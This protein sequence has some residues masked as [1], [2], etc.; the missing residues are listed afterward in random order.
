[1]DQRCIFCVAKSLE[2]LL[3]K[4]HLNENDRNEL[5]QKIFTDLGS[6]SM[7][8]LTPVLAS[9]IH[10]EIRKRLNNQDPYQE[11]KE[12]YNKLMLDLYAELKLKIKT[13]DNSFRTAVKTA[14]A[15][16]I[17]DF[18]ASHNFEVLETLDKVLHSDFAIDDTIE[19]KREIEKAETILYLG[20][21][22][23]EIVAD[24]LLLEE[25]AHKN[26][27]FAVRGNP[28]IND[29][30]EEDAHFVGIDKFAK[31][32]SNGY[33]AP[34]TILEHCSTEF[35][36]IWKKAD[37]VISKGQGNYEGLLNN[38]SKKI[39]FLLMVK[40]DYIAE[41]LNVRKGD[42]VAAKNSVINE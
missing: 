26:V 6:V 13:S 41:K 35:M 32:I 27:Y 3:E 36:E 8:T 38:V 11:E 22:A 4:H 29:I 18:G 25:M 39:F 34:S 20:D 16:N 31:V 30:T 9:K 17:I 10:R 2:K 28:V 23:G 12:K 40:C 1:M 14:V 42:F 5:V 19:L 24:R 7:D 37:I 21:N 15:G 33:D